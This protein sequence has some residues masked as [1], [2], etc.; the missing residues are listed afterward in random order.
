VITLC[1]PPTL[2][3]PRSSHP[4]IT[5][6]VSGS[7]FY[8]AVSLFKAYVLPHLQPPNASAYEQDRDALA[9]QFDAAEALLKDIQTETS[10]I[11]DSVQL[12]KDKIDQ[13]VNQVDSAV[14]DLRQADARAR[15]EMREIRD[16]VNNIRE[17]LPK[18]CL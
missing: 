14:N 5:F 15:D 3:S 18:V 8:G 1:A 9:A 4:K 6:V 17:M 16:E 12:Q 11:K 10:L 13:T 2:P 7:A